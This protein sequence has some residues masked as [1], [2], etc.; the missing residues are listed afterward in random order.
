MSFYCKSGIFLVFK[1][2]FE[3]KELRQAATKMRR[4]G[5]RKKAGLWAGARREL[6][7]EQRKVR[8]SAGSKDTCR[9]G[10]VKH[11]PAGRPWPVQ[12]YLVWN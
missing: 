11:T 1:H 5:L 12:F 7:G 3:L 10:E 6:R 9:T 8:G 2:I 4:C